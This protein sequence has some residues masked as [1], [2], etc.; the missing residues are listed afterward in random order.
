MSPGSHTGSA[1]AQAV[2]DLRV[3]PKGPYVVRAK[4]TSG[5][6]NVGELFRRFLVVEGPVTMATASDA[7][8]NNVAHVAPARLTPRG[9]VPRFSVDQVLGPAVLPGY[10]DRV[11]ARPDAASPEVRQ[12]S[13]VSGPMEP[14]GWRCLTS[15]RGALPFP[16]F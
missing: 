4:V 16:P 3:L 12:L 7:P 15:W 1:L 11:S 13:I 6:E 5:S 14:A 8:V 9:T 10:L 2:A